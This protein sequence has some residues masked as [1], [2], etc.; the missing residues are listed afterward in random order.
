MPPIN[1]LIKPASGLCNMQCDYCFYCDITEKREQASYGIMTERTLRNVIKKTLRAAERSC[2]I[3]YQGGEP[4]LAGL[5]FFKKSIEYQNRFNIKKLPIYNAL[6]TNGFGLTEEWCAFFKENHFLIGLS[7]DGIRQTHDLHRH[8]KSG[9]PTYDRIMKSAKMLEEYG[10]DFNILTVVNKQTAAEIK[11]I[12]QSYKSKGFGFQ[13]YIACLDPLGETC[14]QREYSLLPKDYGRFLIDLFELWYK[15]YKKGC[16]PYIRAFEN[17]I[18]LL[19]GMGAE[20][21]EQNGVCGYQNVVEA[22]GEVYPCDFYVLDEYKLGNLNEVSMEQIYEK[23]RE[24]KYIERSYNHSAACK[25]CPYFHVCRGGC[26]RH[27]VFD[28]AAGEYQNYFCPAYKMFFSECYDKLCDVAADAAKRMR[29]SN[30]G[31]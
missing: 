30:N 5:D 26:N 31:V 20:S 17:Y 19:L 24:M 13:Q 14:G 21:C 1:L 22:D 6:Q 27:R 10:V 8:T 23:R 3:A 28:E 29:S 9:E 11:K 18:S 7:V 12:Y 16:Q 25:S 4:T 2:T 15:D